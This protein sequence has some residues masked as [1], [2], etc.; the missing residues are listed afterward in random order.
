MKKQPSTISKNNKALGFNRA[1]EIYDAPLNDLLFQAHTVFRKNFDPNKIQI[2][3]LYNIKK[4]LCPEDC[5]YCSQSARFKTKL[6]VYPL[7]DVQS[8]IKAAKK[9]KTMGATRCCLAAAWRGPK[10]SDM[11]KLVEMVREIKKLGLESCLSA[12]LLQEGQAK[13][14]KEAGLD[15]YNH[16]IDTS[17]EYYE[18]IITTRKFSDRLDTLKQVADAGIK[19]CSGVILGLGESKDDRISAILTLS[20][21]RPQPESVPINLLVKNPGTPLEHTADLDPLEL[22]RSIATA[23]IL[24]P[25]AYVRLSAGRTKMSNELQALCF[26]AGANSIFYG[27]EL[28]TTPNPNP[29]KDTALLNSLGI[30]AEV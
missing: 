30:A 14:L 5:K 8:V 16:N 13:E 10:A 6:K 7:V 27:D 1:K 21:L 17:E 25:K 26:F 12:G 3:A 29:E 24:I 11:G 20:S 23:R 19:T 22:V 18:K 9:I 4:G 28:L 15:F 2:S